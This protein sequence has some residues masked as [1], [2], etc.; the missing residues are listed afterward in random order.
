MASLLSIL[1]PAGEKPL[2][3]LTPP[4]QGDGDPFLSLERRLLLL[5]RRR[6]G[7]KT[8]EEKRH[9]ARKLEAEG[10]ELRLFG[11]YFETDSLISVSLGTVGITTPNL[12]MRKLSPSN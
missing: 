3:A 7:R 12:Q 9:G 6:W 10:G 4:L 5:K 8:P 11:T 1:P 2:C